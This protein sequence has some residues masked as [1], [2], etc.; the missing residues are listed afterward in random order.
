MAK[1]LMISTSVGAPLGAEKVAHLGGPPHLL[2]D[3]EAEDLQ[4]PGAPSRVGGS[5]SWASLRHPAQM[6]FKKE[7]RIR[8]K[9]E[10]ARVGP[11]HVLHPRVGKQ[12]VRKQAEEPWRPILA[13]ELEAAW[14]DPADLDSPLEP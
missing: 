11:D 6:L 9:Q 5:H 12:D 1:P 13:G 8:E 7:R 3:L 4:S 14:R 10:V 2:H